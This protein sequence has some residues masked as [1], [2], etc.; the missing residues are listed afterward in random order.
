MLDITVQ[1]D[2]FVNGAFQS[3]PD[4]V[5][6]AYLVPPPPLQDAEL[7]FLCSMFDYRLTEGFCHAK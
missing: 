4:F 2:S 7:D 6:P 5:D 1:L 3:L